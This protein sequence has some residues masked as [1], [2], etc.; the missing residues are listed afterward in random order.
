MPL[1]RT[2]SNI[3]SLL[4]LEKNNRIYFLILY[5]ALICQL[6]SFYASYLSNSE[7]D[8]VKTIVHVLFCTWDTPVFRKI[9]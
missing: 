8:F 7:V 3:Y 5:K 9:T 4:F 2:L 1:S 6:R